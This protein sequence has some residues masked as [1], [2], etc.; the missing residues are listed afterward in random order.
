MHVLAVSSACPFNG[1]YIKMAFNEWTNEWM[2]E[3]IIEKQKHNMAI[4]MYKYS[5]IPLKGL[6]Q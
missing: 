3:W 2:N 4:K 6:K 1:H 5:F